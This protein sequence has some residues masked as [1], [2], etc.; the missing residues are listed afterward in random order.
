VAIKNS[1]MI[2]KYGICL[3]D[4]KMLC[5][6][7]WFLAVLVVITLVETLLINVFSSAFIFNF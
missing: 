4:G 5:K 2:K 3:F 7:L 6:W 1:Q